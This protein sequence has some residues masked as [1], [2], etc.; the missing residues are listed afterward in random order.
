MTVARSCRQ[1]PQKI[2]LFLS[3][4]LPR[5][6]HPQVDKIVLA[7]VEEEARRAP[8][9]VTRAKIRSFGIAAREKLLAVASTPAGNKKKLEAFGASNKWA[10][11]FASRNGLLTGHPASTKAGGGAEAELEERGEIARAQAQ[12][13]GDVSVEGTV[14]NPSV[15]EET[16]TSPRKSYSVEPDKAE[17][18]KGAGS[19]EE[20]E[21]QPSYAELPSC[22]ELELLFRPLEIYAESCGLHEAR[23]YLRKAKM[24]FL[25]ASAARTTQQSDIRSFLNS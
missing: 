19:G 8:L 15:Q 17:D 13:A 2:T 4:F 22:A 25:A 18:A 20:A 3:Q 16:N 1:D 11:N 7:W 6:C 14:E 12:G 5:I 24:A 21:A 9:T 10:R 23:D